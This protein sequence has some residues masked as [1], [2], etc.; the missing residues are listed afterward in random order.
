MIVKCFKKEQIKMIVV[1]GNVK[2]MMAMVNLVEV[3]VKKSVILLVGVY[4]KK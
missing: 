4:V 1:I 2:I 3:Y